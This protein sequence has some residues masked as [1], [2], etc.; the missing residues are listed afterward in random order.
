MFGIGVTELLVILAVVLLIYGGKRL[1]EL[2][3]SFGK[4]IRNFRNS[5]TEPDEIDMTPGKTPPAADTKSADVKP[6]AQSPDVEPA[7]KTPP[8]PPPAAAA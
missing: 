8:P 4:A 1:P 5:G 6:D 7:D 3:S 2:G